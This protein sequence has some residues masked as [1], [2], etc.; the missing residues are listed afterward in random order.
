MKIMNKYYHSFIC[1]ECELTGATEI[2]EKLSE[3]PEGTSCP[4]CSSEN[5]AKMG[6]HLRR[7]TPQVL[8]RAKEAYIARDGDMIG[9]NIETGLTVTIGGKTIQEIIAEGEH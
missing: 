2:P 4:H 3:L 7:P 8:R 9:Y 1:K 5:L 6:N